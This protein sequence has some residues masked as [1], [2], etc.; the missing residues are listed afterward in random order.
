MALTAGLTASIRSRWASSSSLA[1]T[2]RSAISRRCS[3]PQ[4][5]QLGRAPTPPP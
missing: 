1:D 2:V 4:V 3:I 5:G